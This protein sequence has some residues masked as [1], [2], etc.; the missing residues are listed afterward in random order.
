MAI[1]FSYAPETGA[2]V[3]NRVH[4]NDAAELAERLFSP[5]EACGVRL[6]A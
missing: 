3:R 6:T 5:A 2:F 1:L 4:V